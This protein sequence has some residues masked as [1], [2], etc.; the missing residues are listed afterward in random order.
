MIAQT[1]RA[2]LFAMATLATRTGFLASSA[3][4]RTVDR[5]ETNMCVEYLTA[6]EAENLHCRC[7]HIRRRLLCGDLARQPKRPLQTFGDIHAELS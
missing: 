4:S 7:R 5:L 2:I 3:T 1:T 6:Q